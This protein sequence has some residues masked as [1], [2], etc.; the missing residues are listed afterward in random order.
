MWAYKKLIKPIENRLSFSVA[1]HEQLLPYPHHHDKRQTQRKAVVVSPKPGV[2]KGVVVVPFHLGDA[3]S[4]GCLSNFFK[5][6]NGVC[7]QAE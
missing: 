7:R 3:K 2:P 6:P 5:D 4:N 1:D